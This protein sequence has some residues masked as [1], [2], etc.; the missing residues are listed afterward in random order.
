MVAEAC[1]ATWPGPD[2]RCATSHAPA[3]AA[4]ARPS[5]A[6]A[7]MRSWASGE[8]DSRS[9][10]PGSATLST[11]VEAAPKATRRGGAPAEFGLNQRKEAAQLGPGAV[12]G[13]GA[14]NR[15]HG[16]SWRSGAAAL[17]RTPSPRRG[18]RYEP[19]RNGPH[20]SG[21]ALPEPPEGAYDPY[22]SLCGHKQ[23][24]TARYALEGSERCSPSG[25][26][27]GDSRQYSRT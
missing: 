18:A 5:S 20:A 27:T 10:S 9:V 6:A 17:P 16:R 22:T 23:A 7:R 24:L 25:P 14:P 4:S 21:T 1:L 11:P 13:D 3:V 2:D 12:P 15:R 19:S 26:P 8:A